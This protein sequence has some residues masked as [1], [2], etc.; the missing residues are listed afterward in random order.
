MAAKSVVTVNEYGK[1]QL[2]L[3]EIMDK[4][5]ITRNYLARAT[6][7]RFEVINKWYNNEVEKMDLDIL[8]R[9]CYVLDCKPRLFC[10]HVRENALCFIFIAEKRNYPLQIQSHTQAVAR[11]T[12]C[13]HT[14]DLG[15]VSFH[16][17]INSTTHSLLVILPLGVRTDR[18]LPFCIQR[19][20]ALTE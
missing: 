20:T 14:K 2:R 5:K 11:R 6:N 8:A 9:I 10:P 4:K 18:S 12:A 16:Q 1:I 3:K 19:L 15:S 7:T 17:R 13:R